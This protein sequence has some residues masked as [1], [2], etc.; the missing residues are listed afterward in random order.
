MV[1]NIDTSKVTV[2]A[3][4]ISIDESVLAIDDDLVDFSWKK[5]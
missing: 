5:Q 3:T 1:K 2:N 4:T